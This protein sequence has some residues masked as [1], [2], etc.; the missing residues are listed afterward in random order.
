[1]FSSH[2]LFWNNN[3]C[4]LFSTLKMTYFI[5]SRSMFI[6]PP[7]PCL[8]PHPPHQLLTGL[9]RNA[10]P[11]WEWGGREGVTHSLLSHQ[12]YKVTMGLVSQPNQEASGV[13]HQPQPSPGLQWQGW[14]FSPDGRDKFDGISL[15]T[16]YLGKVKRGL[17]AGS[18]YLL[19]LSQ[20]VA[21]E[22]GQ[23]TQSLKNR[24][25]TGGRGWRVRRLGQRNSVLPLPH[26]H[27]SSGCF[28]ILSPHPEHRSGRP[29][30]QGPGPRV[31]HSAPPAFRPPPQA[32]CLGDLLPAP[33]LS[34]LGMV[35]STGPAL[36]LLPGSPGM[37]P[38]L[39]APKLH[40]SLCSFF[41]RGT[42]LS[43]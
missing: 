36:H 3:L 21:A 8:S 6:S 20:C 31:P 39:W 24:V 41:P 12:L 22:L 2:I 26:P 13:G 11:A 14:D 29:R 25:L 15:Q 18:S 23:G 19:F 38:G 27:P 5:C 1:M 40:A 43:Q 7:L 34:G 28:L 30:A 32:S 17:V 4:T 33:L 37:L 16:S 35:T 42:S 10:Q 9:L